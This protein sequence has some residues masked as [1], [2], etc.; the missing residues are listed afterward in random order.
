MSAMAE[1]GPDGASLLVVD[2]D[3][4]LRERLAK[5]FRDRGFDVRSAGD[6]E[7]ALAVA[8]D[9]PPELAVVDLRIP[10]GSGIDLVRG[11]KQLDNTTMI[12]VLT[13]YG[14]IATALEAVRLG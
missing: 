7:S 4:V 14:S 10:G 8:R 11:L 2:D 9:E 12:V 1:R 5:A 6:Y 3:R 13:G